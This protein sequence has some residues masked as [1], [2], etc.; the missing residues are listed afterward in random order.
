MKTGSSGLNEVWSLLRLRR[1]AL[2]VIER[3]RWSLAALFI[4]LHLRNKQG[5]R[6]L[7]V[8]HAQRQAKT[9][10]YRRRRESFFP[11]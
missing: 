10:R 9:L 5:Q 8:D 7:L 4:D 2:G 11:E 6:K 3:R 1:G